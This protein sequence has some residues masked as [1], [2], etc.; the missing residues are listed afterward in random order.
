MKEVLIVGANGFLGQALSKKCLELNWTVDALIRT[1]RKNV[2]GGIRNVFDKIEQLKHSYDFIFNA[3]A[4]IPYGK[5]N[6][7]DARLIH[8]NM[9]LPS[10]LYQLYAETR[11][12]YASSVSV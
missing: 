8:S 1:N 5:F 2:S 3:A 12:I 11:V 9:D 4:F 7:P 6:E 10:R